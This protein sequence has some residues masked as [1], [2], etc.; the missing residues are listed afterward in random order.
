MAGTRDYQQTMDR[1][2]EAGLD[3]PD[4]VYACAGDA[5]AFAEAY[6]TCG[7]KDGVDYPTAVAMLRMEY[8]GTWKRAVEDPAFAEMVLKDTAKA[9][10]KAEAVIHL[11]NPFCIPPGDE[12]KRSATDPY[13]LVLALQ[14]LDR[15]RA[16]AI[17]FDLV[18]T[19]NMFGV[20]LHA[21]LEGGRRQ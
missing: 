21:A 2:R 16:A 3:I 9:M 17:I 15:K 10:E 20:A 19:V 14:K 13:G 8:E 4:E 11:V 5:A 12:K 7:Q 18:R 6:E 1:L